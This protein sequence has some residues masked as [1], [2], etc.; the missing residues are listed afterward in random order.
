MYLV[1]IL[2]SLYFKTWEF[3]GNKYIYLNIDVLYIYTQSETVV[4]GRW[5]NDVINPGSLLSS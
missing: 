3:V 5:Q 2:V 1:H 4:G